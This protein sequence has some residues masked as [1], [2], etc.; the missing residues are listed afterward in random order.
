MKLNVYSIFDS[1]AMAYTTPF[2]MPM[3]GMAIR[4]FQANVNAGKE[5]NISQFPDQFTLF[6]VG[7][8]DDFTGMFLSST[9]VSLGNGKQFVE[10]SA[11]STL[12]TKELKAVVLEALRSYHYETGDL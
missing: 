11:L 10:S 12:D 4:A 3:D 9:P 7:E 8:F 1:A 5:N 2:F 6:H